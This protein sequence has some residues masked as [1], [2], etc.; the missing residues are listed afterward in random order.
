LVAAEQVVAGAEVF[1]SEDPG[2]P[3]G[4]IVNAEPAGAGNSL[5]LV[6]IKLAAAEAGSIHLGS[7]DGP[8]LQLQTL[9]YE[10]TDPQ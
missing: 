9:P 4:M 7:V 8:A 5:C 3:C 2:Q 10:L 6:E 1:S